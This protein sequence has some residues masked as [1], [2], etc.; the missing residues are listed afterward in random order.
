MKDIS[1][2]REIQS[3]AETV[4]DTLVES[5]STGVHESMLSAEISRLSVPAERLAAVSALR[6]LSHVRNLGDIF[7]EGVP[8]FDW[9]NM[10]EHLYY[11]CTIYLDKNDPDAPKGRELGF[12][13]DELL[14]LT[15]SKQ[16]NAITP[17]S[18]DE[19]GFIRA[20]LRKVRAAFK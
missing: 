2:V 11:V 17:P 14:L 16:S 5:G 9:P 4:L 12:S 13:A 1:D 19:F 8:G 7:L 3:A 18:S 15:A 6:D 20:F 10:V